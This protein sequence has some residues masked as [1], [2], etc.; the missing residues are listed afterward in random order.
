MT[1]EAS[2]QLIVDRTS[3]PQPTVMM[4]HCTGMSATAWRPL[5]AQVDGRRACIAPDLLGYGRNGPWP[6]DLPFEVE[7][8]LQAAGALL[9][10]EAQ[11]MDLVGH[12]YGGFLAMTLALRYPKRVRRLVLH[13]PVLWGVLYEDG[14][15]EDVASFE[16]INADGRFF[17]DDFGGTDEWLQRF[18]DFWS[19]EGTWAA[20]SEPRRASQ[21]SI[22]AKMFPEVRQLC[23]DRT[24]RATWSA[25]KM[26]VRLTCGRD[27]IRLQKRALELLMPALGDARLSEIP[28][29]HMAPITRARSTA[30]AMVAALLED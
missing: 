4:L 2:S 12:S 6:Q 10:S 20:M 18:V 24:P 19:G 9:L 26:P 8:D 27:T 17:D 23:L 11:P 15:A 21:R 5:I 1:K 25:L 16:A 3:G 14:T 29:A 13:E 22:A 30:D 28:G 7:M